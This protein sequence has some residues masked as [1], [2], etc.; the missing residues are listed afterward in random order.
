MSRQLKGKKNLKLRSAISEELLNLPLSAPDEHP[1][2]QIGKGLI[3]QFNPERSRL[4]STFNTNQAL[5]DR[6]RTQNLPSKNQRLTPPLGPKSEV[7]PL[8]I[9]FGQGSHGSKGRSIQKKLKFI[10]QMEGIGSRKTSFLN[11]GPSASNRKDSPSDAKDFTLINVSRKMLNSFTKKKKPKSRKNS[12]QFIKGLSTNNLFTSRN[13]GSPLLDS[14]QHKITKT[15]GNGSMVYPGYRSNVQS[16]Y[17]N[18]NTTPQTEEHSFK[19]IGNSPPLVNNFQNQSIHQHIQ[20]Q[21]QFEIPKIQD[22]NMVQD[23]KLGYN[24]SDNSGHLTSQESLRNIGGAGFVNRQVKVM[25]TNNS[26]SAASN[27]RGSPNMSIKT[28]HVTNGQEHPS[29]RRTTHGYLR[30]QNVRQ[31]P[32]R[33]TDTSNSR[34]SPQQLAT[35]QNFKEKDYKDLYFEEKDKNRDLKF[36]LEFSSSQV[37]NLHKEKAKLLELLEQYKTKIIKL[38]AFCLSSNNYSKIFESISGLEKKFTKLAKKTTGNSNTSNSE[39]GGSK[40]GRKVRKGVRRSYKNE[41]KKN[42]F[43]RNQSIPDVREMEKLTKFTGSLERIENRLEQL[44]IDQRSSIRTENYALKTENMKLTQSISQ[45]IKTFEN[46]SVSQEQDNQVRQEDSFFKNRKMSV[47]RKIAS[48]S[49]RGGIEKS[50][51]DRAEKSFQRADVLIDSLIQENKE[52]RSKVDNQ[53]HSKGASS[54]RVMGMNISNR[55]KTTILDKEQCEIMKESPNREMVKIEVQR[56]RD[57]KKRQNSDKDRTSIDRLTKN[58]KNEQFY[59]EEPVNDSNNNNNTKSG[60]KVNTRSSSFLRLL[61]SGKKGVIDFTKDGVNI[62]QLTPNQSSAFVK[63]YQ[64]GIQQMQKNKLFKTYESERSPKKDY[65]GDTDMDE[66]DSEYRDVITP[67]GGP[68]TDIRRGIKPIKMIGKN[69]MFKK[70]AKVKR[71]HKISRNSSN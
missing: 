16:A 7:S 26:F 8:S 59:E 4:G 5:Q 3:P 19:N 15:Y 64:D 38:E 51:L 37:I 63:K 9:G 40:E 69:R 21:Q 28:S 2:L 67:G 29:Y 11:K 22:L 31:S 27:Q 1:D 33:L 58:T 47:F 52:L 32:P 71:S 24:Q 46:E 66:D 6:R 49:R 34:G 41:T 65:E 56:F 20:Q 57:A 44:T 12:T 18:H 62:G 43:G 42:P 54:K 10:T 70:L 14:H 23:L 60:R 68:E 39:Q 45:M 53:L 61:A 55:L 36:K 48:K 13:G 50:S 25:P 30:F 17:F 35:P